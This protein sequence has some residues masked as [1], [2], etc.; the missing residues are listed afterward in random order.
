MDGTVAKSMKKLTFCDVIIVVDSII[1]VK[2]V[3]SQ[4]YGKD[5]SKVTTK[6]TVLKFP[7]AV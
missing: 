4:L 6:K 5:V 2:I 7:L 1:R 3:D